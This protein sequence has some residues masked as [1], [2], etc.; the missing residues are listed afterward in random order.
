MSAATMTD[1][2]KYAE[3]GNESM[4]GPPAD[5][6]NLVLFVQRMIEQRLIHHGVP[7]KKQGLKFYKPT[8]F[9]ST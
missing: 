8:N 5:P 7:F 1:Y 6:E 3:A 4:E 2:Q 9:E